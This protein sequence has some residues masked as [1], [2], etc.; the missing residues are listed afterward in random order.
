M[1]HPADHIR[2]GG[3]CQRQTIDTVGSGEGGIARKGML[4]QV[5][6]EVEVIRVSINE[7]DSVR[8]FSISTCKRNEKL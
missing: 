3:G 4:D 5:R 7:Q 2:I 1:T 8:S 6:Q